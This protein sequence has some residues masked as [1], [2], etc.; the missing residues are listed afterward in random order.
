TLKTNLKDV[1]GLHVTVLMYL[2]MAIICIPIGLYSN[3]FRQIPIAMKEGNSL[4]HL[5]AL[6]V[7]GSAIA[8]ALFNILV[9]R[10]HILFAASVTF[11]MPIVSVIVGVFDGERIRWNDLLGLA[12]I[13]VGVLL[14]NNLI[15]KKM[16]QL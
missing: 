12:L 11:L 10:V 2:F 8:M 9:K 7:L 1:S 4:Y 13:L 16:L 6:S 5:L 14:I 3:A 15:G